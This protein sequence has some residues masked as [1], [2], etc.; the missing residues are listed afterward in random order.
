MPNPA[1]DRLFVKRAE[2]REVTESWWVGLVG[3]E[4]FQRRVAEEQERM[5]ESRFGRTSMLWTVGDSASD[6]GR[7][8]RAK[9]RRLE[10]TS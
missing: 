1:H 6:D 5:Q 10:R 8:R 3:R 7:W 2:V 4:E 9:Q